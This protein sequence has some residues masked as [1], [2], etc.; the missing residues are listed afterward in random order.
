MYPQYFVMVLPDLL[1][2]PFSGAYFS[3]SCLEHRMGFSL[4]ADLWKLAL[5]VLI[6]NDFFFFSWWS[7]S[8]QYV[9]ETTSRKCALVSRKQALKQMIVASNK[10]CWHAWHRWLLSGF[11]YWLLLWILHSF[12]SFTSLLLLLLFQNLYFNSFLGWNWI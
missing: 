7:T 2:S 6:K 8:D 11:V 5:S 10:I 12:Q 1:E 4:G 9:F 3:G